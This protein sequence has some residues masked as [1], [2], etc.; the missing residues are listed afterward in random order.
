MTLARV[1]ALIIV[2]VLIITAAVVVIMAIG[3]DTQI[4]FQ[5]EE[6]AP[7]LVPAKTKMPDEVEVT[8]HVYNGTK[9]Q[10]LAADVA[11]DFENRGFTAEE[12][13][14]SPPEGFADRSFEDE[15]AVIVFG[16]EAVGAGYLVSAYFLVDE[17]TLEFDIEREG[18]V[19]DV[20]IGE[21][22]QQLATR[23]EV[24]QSIAAIGHPEAPEGTCA[25][26]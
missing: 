2:S 22:F 1:R 24:N 11:F 13:T 15:V 8:V 3:K 20:I 5:A 17:A 25:I 21:D 14:E 12:P 9:K 16:P 26:D 18:A 6:C 4:N 10:D 19:V 7:G 23:T